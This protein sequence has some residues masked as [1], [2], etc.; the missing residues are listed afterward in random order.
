MNVDLGCMMHGFIIKVGLE[1]DVFIGSAL[2]DMYNN[3]LVFQILLK[4]YFFDV[5]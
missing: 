2:L 5:F 1:L 4:I 3:Y